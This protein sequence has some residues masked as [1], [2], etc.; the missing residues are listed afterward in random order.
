MKEYIRKIYSQF[1][2]IYDLIIKENKEI[3][4][5]SVMRDAPR[6]ID[7][8]D[9]RIPRDGLDDYDTARGMLERFKTDARAI[10]S[11]LNRDYREWFFKES[12]SSRDR[13]FDRASRRDRDLEPSSRSRKRY[14]SDDRDDRYG[15]SGRSD[16]YSRGDRNRGGRDRR[17]SADRYDRNRSSRYD[18]RR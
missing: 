2:N 10:G 17:R 13:D 9:V 8:S 18:R 15:R 5:N 16:R 1:L 6:G 4:K 11:K 12:S 14:G 3:R 7:R